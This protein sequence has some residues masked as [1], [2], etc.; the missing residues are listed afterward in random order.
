MTVSV[1]SS[2]SHLNQIHLEVNCTEILFSVQSDKG[3]IKLEGRET[4][5]VTLLEIFRKYTLHV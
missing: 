3:K 4:E 2:R 1:R 5:G